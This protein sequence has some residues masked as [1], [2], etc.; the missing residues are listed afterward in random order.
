MGRAS[1]VGDGR[2]RGVGPQDAAERVPAPAGEP[3]PGTRLSGPDLQEEIGSVSPDTP[4]REQPDLLVDFS[5][6]T[7]LKKKTTAAKALCT[8]CPVSDA[9]TDYAIANDYRDGIW[10]GLTVDER[11][12]LARE[13]ATA[14]ADEN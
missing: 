5:R 11:D 8:R 4:C 9:C 1:R 10:G 12:Q 3:A 7:P 14:I 2:P 6:T 13:R